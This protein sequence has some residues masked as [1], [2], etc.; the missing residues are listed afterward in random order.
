[1]YE[2]QESG[3]T[4]LLDEETCFYIEH[5]SV[6]RHINSHGVASVEFIQAIQSKKLVLVEAKTSVVDKE[7]L[8][9]LDEFLKQ[10]VKKYRDSVSLC[11]AM[12]HGVH[13]EANKEMP[14]TIIDSLGNNPQFVF[15]LIVK[16][17]RD[18]D[19]PVLRDA[20]KQRMMDL[21]KIWNTDAVLVLSERMARKRGWLKS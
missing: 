12:L 14:S 9:R 17:I 16:N 21:M 4:F 7:N 13:G 20:L 11:Y 5:S 8:I 18:E 3:M 15:L 19:C 2:I 10:I 1:M 6:Y